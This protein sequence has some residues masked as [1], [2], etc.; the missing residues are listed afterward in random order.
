MKSILRIINNNHH[1]F[2]LYNSF[3]LLF[4]IRF[5]FES[6]NDLLLPRITCINYA[7][8]FVKKIQGISGAVLS[9]TCINF[10]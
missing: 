10:I 1:R 2:F 7:C 8:I 6:S 4:L 5:L 9:T 3:C